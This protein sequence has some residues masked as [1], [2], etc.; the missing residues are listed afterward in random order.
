MNENVWS[1]FLYLCTYYVCADN[2]RVVEE[3]TKS[4]MEGYMKYRN[5][6]NDV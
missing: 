6:S 4:K 5:R 1:F 2:K 3:E